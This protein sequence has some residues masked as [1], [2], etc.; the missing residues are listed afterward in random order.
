MLE[1]TPLAE[2][3]QKSCTMLVPLVREPQLTKS[4]WP[5]AIQGTHCLDALTYNGEMGT[6]LHDPSLQSGRCAVAWAETQ[7]ILQVRWL[8]IL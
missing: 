3:L 2:E 1:L 7:Y 6:V 4:A 8:S 5:T